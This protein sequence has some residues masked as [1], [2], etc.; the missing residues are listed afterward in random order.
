[1]VIAVSDKAALTTRPVSKFETLV[2]SDNRF[3]IW[4][5]EQLCLPGCVVLVRNRWSVTSPLTIWW[6]S[7]RLNDKDGGDLLTLN[8]ACLKRERTLELSRSTA[9]H[10]PTLPQH[11]LRF[12][13]YLSVPR[14]GVHSIHK[15]G[16]LSAFSFLPSHIAPA[17]CRNAGAMMWS[18]LEDWKGSKTL[19]RGYVLQL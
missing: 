17:V 3:S 4:G 1:M 7:R 2:S 14:L 6:W 13:L 10:S 16:D 12:H 15:S 11:V 8:G 5:S 19:L 18:E 9:K